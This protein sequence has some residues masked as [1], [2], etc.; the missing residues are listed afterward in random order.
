M[1][2]DAVAKSEEEVVAVYESESE[3]EEACGVELGYGSGGAVSSWSLGRVKPFVFSTRK[4]LSFI[5]PGW[6]MSL[7]GPH[8]GAS[9][10]LHMECLAIHYVRSPIHP[11]RDRRREMIEP[12]ES[13]G[14]TSLSRRETRDVTSRRA[15]R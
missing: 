9:T 5:G 8:T 1:A 4:L 3:S 12:P 10:I 6:L 14:G 11:W 13:R 2:Y 15:L 7:A